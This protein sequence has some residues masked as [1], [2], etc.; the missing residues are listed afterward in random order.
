MS[1]PVD[2]SLKGTLRVVGIAGVACGLRSSANA[3]VAWYLEAKGTEQG[4]FETEVI[5]GTPFPLLRMLT[6]T[7]A[8]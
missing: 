2:Q 6:I 5:E 8:E 1:Y 4:M 7:F 3:V